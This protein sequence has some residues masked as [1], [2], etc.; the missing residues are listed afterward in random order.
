M[1]PDSLRTYGIEGGGEADN[2]KHNLNN[3]RKP[4]IPLEA[5]GLGSTKVYPQ[6]DGLN[7]QVND[8]EA[9]PNIGP[10]DELRMYNVEGDNMSTL[11]LESLE[12]ARGAAPNLATIDNRDVRWVP[13]HFK[14]SNG[15][16]TTFR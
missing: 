15:E 12:S 11:S 4:V 8:L 6:D 2:I 13:P 1:K 10:Y 7:A 9:D 14:S 5:N 16:D 3:L